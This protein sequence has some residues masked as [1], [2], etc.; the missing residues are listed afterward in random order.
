MRLPTA[1]RAALRWATPLLAALL[2]LPATAEVTASQ[3]RAAEEY[4]A[5]VAAGDARAMSLAI[6]EQELD[7]LRRRLLDDM[8]LEEERNSNL[9]RSR[10]FGEGMPLTQ[11]ERLTSQGFFV[12]LASRLRFGGRPF[13]SIDWLDIVKD[14]GGMVQV[15]GRARPL[16]NQGS[17]RV[18][19]LVSLVPWGKD[20]KAALPLELQAQIEDL[21]AGRVRAPA[22]PVAAAT[23]APPGAAAGAP[24]A[25]ASPPAILELLKTAEDNL[26]AGRCKAYFEDQMSP[27]F[28][29][30]TSAKALRAL[31]T[32]C[33]NRTAMRESILAALRFAR[34][35]SPRFEYA[36]S[37][38]VYD[39]AGKGLPFNQLVV[40]QVNRRWY[41]AE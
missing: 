24:T 21:R 25:P 11:I 8:Q 30:T 12:A 20:W 23:S 32:S 39:L 7:L 27:S 31:I 33:E 28:R 15:V 3:G 2:A 1:F 29:R 4:L 17:I 26:V 9:T 13:E 38:A 6:H 36:G 18:P 41:I 10:L 34:E 14:S 5:A 22:A 35:S 19:V 40:E 16:K 37:R